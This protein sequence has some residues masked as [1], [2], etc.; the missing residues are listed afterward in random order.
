MTVVIDANSVILTHEFE[1]VT[2]DGGV[3]LEINSLNSAINE[4]KSKNVLACPMRS[5]LLKMLCKQ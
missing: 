2:N 1:S 3:G 4:T 5:A